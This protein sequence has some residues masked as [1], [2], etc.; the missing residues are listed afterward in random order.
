MRKYFFMHVLHIRA[1]YM[2]EKTMDSYLNVYGKFFIKP[3]IKYDIMT[4]N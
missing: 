3:L 2:Y 4:Q 1:S